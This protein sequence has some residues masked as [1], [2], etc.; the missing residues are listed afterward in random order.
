MATHMDF[1]ASNVPGYAFPVHLCG[2]EVLRFYPFGPTG[3]SSANATMITYRNTCFIGINSDTAAIPDTAAF[4][5]CL[6]EGF[7]E[8]L[9]LAAAGRGEAAA[10][11]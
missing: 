11:G 9:A 8:V 5:A 6:A 1:A 7:D 2:A 3:G 4:M 10:A